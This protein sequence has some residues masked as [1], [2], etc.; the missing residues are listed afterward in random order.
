MLAIARFCILSL[1]VTLV[2]VLLGGCREEVAPAVWWDGERQRMELGHQLELLD[3]KLQQSGYG[4][5]GN[6]EKLRVSNRADQ[7]RLEA[8][9]ANRSELKVELESIERQLK[10]FKTAA[11]LQQ[12][13][14]AVGRT[15]DTFESSDGRK[16]HDVSVV[17]VEDAGVTLRH[18]D[19]SARLRYADLD[20][21]QRDFFGLEE[22]VALAAEEQE[23]RE[24]LAYERW[25]DVRV[26]AAREKEALAIASEEHES[27]LVREMRFLHAPRLE[28]PQSLA[29]NQ[30]P[31]AQPAKSVGRG[32]SSYNRSYRRSRPTYRYVFYNH[33]SPSVPQN[34]SVNRSQACPVAGSV[35]PRPHD[36]NPLRSHSDHSTPCPP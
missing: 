17:S 3:Y 1:F 5:L 23:A 11:L 29:R 15:F 25:I 34:S 22:G 12:R 20:P 13:R 2:A 30:R 16:F 10:S 27:R 33:Y 8:L 28:S 21:Q 19:G 6:L 4:L 35:R 9:L 31:L 24:A 32:F 36:L 14:R 26:A 7:V 18:A